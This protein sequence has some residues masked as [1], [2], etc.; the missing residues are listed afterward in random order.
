MAARR[1]RDRGGRARAAGRRR[2]RRSLRAVFDHVTIRVSDRAASE[3]F[4]DTVLGA[5]GIERTHTATL[6]E[7]DDFSLVGPRAGKPVTRGLHIGFGAAS[8]RD[9]EGSGSAGVEAG[10]E[11]DGEPGPRPITATTT[12]AASCSTRTA[13]ASRRC[14]SRAARD[15]RRRPPL[16]PGGRRAGLEALLRDDRAARALRARHRHARAGRF[17]GPAGL[18]LGASRATT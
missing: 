4:Y 8:A 1:R 12:T 15:R 5:I 6:A 13:T 11:S 10:Y 3:R 2:G 14:T 16:D 7:W 9:V 17:A 18:L